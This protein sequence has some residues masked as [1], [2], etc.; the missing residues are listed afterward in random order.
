MS[1]ISTYIYGNNKT[2]WWLILKFL[3][4]NNPKG[5]KIKTMRF[6]M[7]WHIHSSLLLLR[8]TSRSAK[9]EEEK[10]VTHLIFISLNNKSKYQTE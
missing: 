6:D 1:V 8:N 10:Q 9:T 3:I 5:R 2:K 4:H 7:F